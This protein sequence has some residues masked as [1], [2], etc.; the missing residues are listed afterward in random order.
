[1]SRRVALYARV[2]TRDQSPDLQLDALRSLAVQRGWTLAGEYVDHGVSGT[3]AS[4]PALD[5]LLRDVHA[6]KC[7]VVAVWKFTS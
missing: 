7:D 1:M 2:S 6:G 3:R 5:E 4:R